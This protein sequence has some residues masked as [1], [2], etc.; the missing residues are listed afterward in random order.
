MPGCVPCTP[1]PRLPQR[2][3]RAGVAGWWLFPAAPRG[4][5]RAGPPRPGGVP[6]RGAVGTGG[7]CLPPRGRAMS[8]ATLGDFLLAAKT[9]LDRAGDAGRDVRVDADIEDL[10]RSLGR[11]STA[12]GRYVQDVTPVRRERRSRRPPEPAAWARARA[13]ARDALATAA[14]F[15][16][17]S[18]GDWPLRGPAVTAM[19]QD[20]DAAAV[21][22]AAGR[23]LLQTHVALAAD[24]TRQPRSGWAMVVTSPPV[25]R[26]LLAELASMAEPIAARG[27]DLAL[28]PSA[29]G[30]DTAE[31]R[32]R[33]SA[34]CQARRLPEAGDPVA[35][36]CEGTI[37]SAERV[38]QLAWG[39]AGRAVW[40]PAMSV[41]SLHQAAAA[42]TVTSHNCEVVLKTLAKRTAGP[43]FGRVSAELYAAAAAARRARDCWF[44]AASAV[45]RV[46]TDTR[47]HV[48]PA[49]AEARDLASWTGRL[50]YADPAWTLASGP[51]QHDRSPQ[52]LAPDADLVPMA[53][54]AVHQASETLIRLAQAEQEQIRVAGQ[55][56]RILV[57]T[58]S[59]LPY[60][61]EIR[62]P[63][64]RAPGRRVDQLL[65][66]YR[67]A[68]QAS[69][70]ATA[71]VGAVAE[72]TRAPSRVLT[73]AWAAADAALGKS[74]SYRGRASFYGSQVVPGGSGRLPSEARDRP[75][76]VESK[77]LDL[78]VTSPDTL[79]RAAEIDRTGDRLVND[80]AA[81]QGLGERPDVGP[82]GLNRSVGT[83][84]PVSHEL[85]SG[86]PGAATLLRPPPSLQREPPERE[87]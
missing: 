50:A 33:F 47:G 49:A 36:L 76:P 6:G 85:A 83:A 23:D 25:T 17:R 63:F 51:R 86:D 12:M 38:R 9:H 55:V 52:S 57:S 71:A 34:A 78:G 32:R 18:A 11:V 77:L 65:S 29:G 35:V 87:P 27:A 16:S 72:V 24:G 48:S 69:R 64:T 45:N 2:C 4:P 42:S 8:R 73:A 26:A 31:S 84:S 22:L 66:Y 74:S 70:D 28:S 40:S 15:L 61:F 19:G 58:R 44:Q 37:A 56:G 67:E 75:G 10:C 60:E 20:L 30:P 82:A 53:V 41:T 68:G 79:R 13:E 81:E 43:E 62:R 80:T 7:A 21:S 59:L 39:A 3:G 14:R 46:T 5:L 1:G 54:A